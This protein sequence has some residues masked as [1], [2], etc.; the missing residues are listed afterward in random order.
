MPT[1]AKTLDELFASEDPADVAMLEWVL[2]EMREFHR[3]EEK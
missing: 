3:R 1:N 2:A